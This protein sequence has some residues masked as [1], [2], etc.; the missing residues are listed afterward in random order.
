M[1]VERLPIGEHAP[2]DR[3]CLRIE[4]EPDGSFRLTASALCTDNEDPDSVSMS[5]ETTF[6]TADQAE[7][8][9]LAWA[10]GVGVE[11]L[12]VSKGTLERP[13]EQMEIDRP[14]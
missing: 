12:F 5:P 4:Q 3:D 1:Q 6:A 13:L 10:I 14:L 11:Q 9:G 2:T 8:A 7:A